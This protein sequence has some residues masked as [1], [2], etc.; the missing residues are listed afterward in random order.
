M[1]PERKEEIKRENEELIQTL[2]RVPIPSLICASG[3]IT[4][5]LATLE[6]TEHLLTDHG[7]NGRNYTNE[8]YVTLQ[9]ELAEAQQTIATLSDALKHY[10]VV[11]VVTGE[12][13]TAKKALDKARVSLGE[14]AKT[15]A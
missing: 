1:T 15:D 3:Q 14:G 2:K 13:N 10:V 9:Q 8:Q 11:N 4:E 5:L 7:P 12:G 6:E